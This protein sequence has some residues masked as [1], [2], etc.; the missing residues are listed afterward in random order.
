MTTE[1]TAE[2]AEVPTP[3]RARAVLLVAL[4]NIRRWWPAIVLLVVAVA[5]RE[6]AETID[7]AALRA[8]L[9]GV[10]R[11]WLLVA[12]A[13][14]A[15]NL[16]VMGAYDVVCLPG[17][18]SRRRRLVFGAVA[19]AWSNFLTLGP[20]AGPAIRFWLYP[21]RVRRAGA[22]EAGITRIAVGFAGGLLAWVVAALVGWSTVTVVVAAVAAGL[23]LGLAAT[24]VQPRLAARLPWIG[25]DTPWVRLLLLGVLDWGCAAAVFGLVLYAAG[26]PVGAPT[27]RAFILGQALG[28]VSFI[29]GGFGSADAYWLYRLA[30]PDGTVPAGLIWYRLLYYVI[31]WA[32]ASLFLLRL[33]AG[34]GRRFVAVSR[35]VLSSI[36]GM[37]GVLLLLSSASPAIAQR[38]ALVRAVLPLPVLELSHT[39]AALT[40]LLLLVVARGMMKGFEA[41]YRLAI[42]ACLAG[43][44]LCLGKGLDFEEALVLFAVTLLLVTQGPAFRRAS[45]GDWLGWPGLGMLALAVFLFAAFG[46]A[47]HDADASFDLTLFGHRQEAARFARAAATLGLVTTVLVLRTLLRAPGSFHR[48]TAAEVDAALALHAGLGDGANALMVANRDKAI[49]RAAGD[50]GLCLYRTVGSYLVVFGDPSVGERDRSDFVRELLEFGRTIDRR[51]VL[52]QISA[53]WLPVLHD[54]GYHFFKLGEEAIVPLAN[55]SLTGAGNKSLR[56]AVNRVEREG[57]TCDVVPA[58]RVSCLLPDLRRVS[59]A[60]LAAKNARE[61]QFSI[62]F[63]DPEYLTRFPCVV[64]RGPTGRI[65]A[66][67]NV[68]P[69]P[70]QIELSVDLMR[71]DD[72]APTGTMDVL[73][74]RLFAWGRE[75]GYARFNLGM[76]PLATVGALQEARPSE[77]LAHLLFKHGEQWYNF[78]GLRQYKDKFHPQWFPRYLAY[79]DA[80]EWVPVLAQVTRL[81]NTRPTAT[82]LEVEP[83]AAA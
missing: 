70:R 34:R 68:L 4:A 76:A 27:L 22:L 74:V 46:L 8:G 80:W 82:N 14:T 44:V 38:L 28:V 77:R 64:A 50:R 42:L 66:F 32:A 62:G 43:A 39:A 53:D 29:P 57:V 10:D 49:Y 54:Y 15:A 37:A 56:W 30:G 25:T 78:R 65:V 24:R 41:A 59:D 71:H 75:Q 16:A 73:F 11:G 52:Y 5:T 79:P 61:R 35:T 33:A 21:E 7:G 6:A 81:I 18:G 51:V 60:W 17:V 36:I 9:H 2:P 40:G 13:L 1:E 69:G 45:R 83:A 48:P 58:D 72:E 67:A 55:W 26:V 23:A 31:P 19:F 47:V 63:F 20:V 3:S 12:A